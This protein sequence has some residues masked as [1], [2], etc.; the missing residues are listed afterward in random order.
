MPKNLVVVIREDPQKSHRATEAIRIALGL[1]TGPNPLTVIL[2]GQAR[3]LVTEEAYDLPDGEI[4]EKYLPVIQNLQ[5]PIYLDNSRHDNMSLDPE[6]TI[7]KLSD[8]ELANVLGDA[9]RVLVF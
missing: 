4:L 6:F 2:I 8:P 5:L 7:K 1:S 3:L 9:E